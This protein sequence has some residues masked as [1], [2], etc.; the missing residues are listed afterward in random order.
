M[1]MYEEKGKTCRGENID[2]EEILINPKKQ[3]ERDESLPEEGRGNNSD[4]Y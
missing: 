2:E 4:F 1:Q 3:R